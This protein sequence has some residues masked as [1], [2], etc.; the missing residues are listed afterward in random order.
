VF[1]Q[2]VNVTFFADGKVVSTLE[3]L[4][5]EFEVEGNM[6]QFTAEGETSEFDFVSFQVSFTFFCH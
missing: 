4:E 3:T 1:E 6:M 5:Y 2:A